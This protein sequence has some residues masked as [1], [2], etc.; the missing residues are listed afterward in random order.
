MSDEKK[1]DILEQDLDTEEMNAVSGG[2]VILDGC[3][4]E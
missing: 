2:K 1:Q 4:Y 3:T